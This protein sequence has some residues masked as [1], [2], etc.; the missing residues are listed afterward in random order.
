MVVWVISD[1]ALDA[2]DNSFCGNML[3]FFLLKYLGRVEPYGKAVFITLYNTAILASF[4]F[5]N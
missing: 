4:S 5:S 2:Q 3:P 1:F